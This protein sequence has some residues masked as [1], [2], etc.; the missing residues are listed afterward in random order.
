M[1]LSY[2]VISLGQYATIDT[3]NNDEFSENANALLRTFGGTGDPLYN[4]IQNLSPER[5]SEDAN[6][7]YDV[8][9]GG[10]YD[11]FRINNGP[12]QL[13]DAVAVYNATVTFADGS[14][15]NITAVVFQDTAGNTYLA[16]DRFAGTDNTALGS[17][18][19]T[20][21]NLTS[22]VGSPG[23]AT[24]DQDGDMAA[25]RDAVDFIEPV[26]GTAGNDFMGLGYT[27]AQGDQIT[28]GNDYIVAG[29]GNDSVFSG[30]GND[31]I[32]GEDGN[33][34]LDGG[35][36]NDSLYGGAGTDTLLAGFGTDVF[37]G[38]SGV[39]VLD[40]QGSSVGTFAFNI[41][42]ATGTDT[43][44]NTYSSIETI[45]GGTQADTF[46]GASTA[47]TF[48]GFAGNDTLNGGG[49]N[50]SLYG[51]DGEDSVNGGTGA[52]VIEGGA[53]RDTLV[54]GDDNDTFLF[55]NNFGQDTVSGGEGGF[56][57]DTLNFSALAA[58]VTATLSAAKEGAVAQD[59]NNVAFSQIERFV[60][61][62]FS[63]VLDGGPGTTGIAIDALGGDD[64]VYGGAGADTIDGGTGNDRIEGRAGA[65]TIFGGT[66]DDTIVGYDSAN[67]AA[68]GIIAGSDDGSADY[69]D[70]GDGNDIIA[71]GAG[72][73]TLIGGADRDTIIGGAG[74]DVLTGG[75]GNDIF[76]Y[77]P[78]DGNDTISDFN[79]GNTGTLSDDDNA[80]NDFIDLSA[81]YD[82]IGELYADYADNNLLDQ[83]NTTKADGRAVDYEDNT[84]FNGGSI[85]FAGASGDPSF[86]TAEN[87]GVVCFT[88]GTMIL[89]LNGEVPIERLR[90][91]DLIV[92]RDNGVQALQWVAARRITAAELA[93]NPRLRPIALAPDLVGANRRLL[94]SPQHGMLIKRRGQDEILV[95]A[96]HLA[97]LKGGKARVVKSSQPVVYFHLMFE[98]HQII[99]ANGAASESFYPG[100]QALAALADGPAREFQALFPD[101]CQTDVQN[102][103]GKTARTFEPFKTLPRHQKDLMNW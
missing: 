39:D 28:N 55:G 6:D 60:L 44:G 76:M 37:S 62:E 30:D 38:G 88:S 46:T 9:N 40:I 33:D 50:D 16:P 36:G 14:T 86:F 69:I 8:D 82:N 23:Q 22:I 4:H 103:Y 61:T 65:D 83:S 54:G 26:N 27:D 102:A 19:I 93:R 72:N 68:G 24:G 5:L 51:G 47:E 85:F 64:S 45:L 101:L 90:P 84:K 20:S 74:N 71:G 15:A 34:R 41:N 79:A 89:T 100:P 31:Q 48:F 78:G 63:D 12:A 17:G 80:N 2:E 43:Y 77:T 49:G 29:A 56:N 59:T 91:G 42:L 95:R 98:A 13:F 67:M 87:T 75:L 66:G 53:G 73:D 3:D 99:F 35:N 96:T 7:T 92:T 25:D 52:D 81:Y 11:S 1:A 58:P 18:P 21:L 70:G 57:Y 94:V 97:K 32:L 10:G